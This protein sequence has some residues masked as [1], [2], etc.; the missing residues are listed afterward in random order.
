[1]T[2]LLLRAFGGLVF[3]LA[4]LALALFASAGSLAYWQAWAYLAVF[5]I[6]VTLITAYLVRN[7]PG[8]LSRRVQA[9]PV[10]ES[11]PT[12]KVI[13][14]LASL[15]FILLFIVPGLDYRFHWSN[16]PVAAVV[17]SDVMGALGLLVVFLVFRENSYTSAVVEVSAEQKVVTTGPYAVVRHPMYAGAM[18]LVLFTPTALGSWFAIPTAVALALVIAARLLSE[19]KLLQASLTGYDAYCHKVR[20]HLIPF[21]W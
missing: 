14:S 2:Q 5:A 13:Q 1:M 19:E 18:L 4:V 10:A 17:F 20:Y 7:D 8:L 9:G 12:Q 16:V 6:C 11:D 3:L 21:I 15:C